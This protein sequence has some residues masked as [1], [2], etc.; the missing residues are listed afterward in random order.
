VRP[1]LSSPFLYR[2]LTVNNRASLYALYPLEQDSGSASMPYGSS[3][4]T[5]TQR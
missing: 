4:Q 5:E 1:L 3:R 2:K